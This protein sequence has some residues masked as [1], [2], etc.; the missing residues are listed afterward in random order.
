MALLNVS[1]LLKARAALS[2]QPFI[3]EDIEFE[4]MKLKPEHIEH[5]Q[6]L[7]KYEE[8][9]KDAADMGLSCDRM[10]VFDDEELSK[11]MAVI[12]GSQDLDIDSDPCIKQRVG[13]KIC[14]ISGLTDFLDS[15]LNPVIDGD[16][17][18]NMNAT[19][20]ELE[21]DAH[22]ALNAAS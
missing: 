14:E 17:E 20:G 12:W 6:S 21:D 11:D 2:I 9:L 5:I 8:I 7:D 15:I 10:R 1:K 4:I 13:E 16:K 18:L 22:A 19:L 3:I